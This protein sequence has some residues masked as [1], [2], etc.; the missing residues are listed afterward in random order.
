MKFLATIEENLEFGELLKKIEKFGF[1]GRV[2][3]TWK[4][5]KLSRRLVAVGDYSLYRTHS[6]ST[7][8]LADFPGRGSHGLHCPTPPGATP[9]G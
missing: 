6:G 3:P 1:N 7:T 9:V 5:N 8:K 2:Y 4:K